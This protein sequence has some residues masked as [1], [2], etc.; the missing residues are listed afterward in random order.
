MINEPQGFI[1]LFL[2]QPTNLFPTFAFPINIR[3]SAFCS[4]DNFFDKNIAKNLVTSF[5]FLLSLSLTHR[6]PARRSHAF[7][8]A[9]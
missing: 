7:L 8:G 1:F 3:M 4:V 6:T 9:K 2:I 5:L